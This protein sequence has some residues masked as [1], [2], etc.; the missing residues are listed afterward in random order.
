M[1]RI[2]L[3][4]V[5]TWVAW[6]IAIP[7]AAMALGIAV[8]SLTDV[9]NLPFDNPHL[10]WLGGAVPL[11]SLLFLYGYERRR[12]A[13]RR[14]VSDEL[15]PLLAARVRPARQALKSGLVVMAILILVVAILGP[16]W[17]IYM[18]KQK[19]YGV[20][21]VVAVDVSRSMLA[22]DVEPNRL[23]HALLAIRQQLTERAVF[24]RAH[25]LA[26][27]A[28]AGSTS[29]KLPLTT[30]HLA[31]R[32]KLATINIYSAPL[33]G[34]TIAKTIQAAV[35][36]F[37]KSPEDA[38]KIIL[39]F[40]D[41]EDHEGDPIEAA[42]Q[43]YAEHGVRVFTV[44]VGDPARAAGA[45]VPEAPG[46]RKPL[47][48][49]GQIVFSKLDVRGLR[50]IAEAGHGEYAAIRDLHVLVDAVSKMHRSELS[51]EE[52]QRH[53]PRFQWFIALALLLLGIESLT[54]EYPTAKVD[55]PKRVWQ[56][57]TQA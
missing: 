41:G 42:K 20:D 31:F 37:A 53:R 36:L 27:L 48:H 57:E 17:G 45:E 29:L 16:R 30:D 44:A 14:F 39:L 34:T 6:T 21:I 51:T 26:L 8:I 1:K 32:E 50:N 9:G 47:L 43:A 35:D 49:D 28:F 40:T 15:N 4:P 54:A 18:E 13:L 38:T 55:L 46:S 12:R 33:G 5:G 11:A 23:D 3:Y 56:M 25:R 2:D 19:V 52:R 24:Q 7:L 22:S 10:W